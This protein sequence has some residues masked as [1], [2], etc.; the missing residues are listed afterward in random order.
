MILINVL[1]WYLVIALAG[2]LAFPLAFRL[3]PFLT[4]R[5]LSLSRPLGML[6]WGYV[7]W[8]LVS[9]GVLQN[10]AEGGLFALLCC[11]C[12]S[13]IMLRRG[14]WQQI[15][16]WL[17]NNSRLVAATEAVFLVSFLAWVVIRAAVPDA[18]GTE[19]PMELAFINSIL[20]SPSFPPADPWLSGYAISYY[21]FGYVLV[22]LL[23]RMVSVSGAVAFNLGIATWFALTALGAYGIL[24]NLIM[25][26]RDAGQKTGILASLLAPLFMLI[27]GNLEG[28][29]EMLHARGIFWRLDDSGAW[30]SGFWS[31]LNIQ[32]L[33]NPPATPLSWVPNRPF[34]IWWWRASRVLQD[35]ALDG[36]SREVIDEFPMFS[37]ILGD[38]HPHVLAMPF[39]LLAV[40]LALNIFLNRKASL[41]NRLGL[42]QWLKMPVF[43]LTSLVLGGLS[44]LNTWDFPIF[45]VLFTAAMVFPS[46]L[47]DG[48]RAELVRDFLGLAFS[49]GLAGFTLYLPFYLAFASQANG[50]LPSLVFFTRGIHLWVMFGLLLLPLIAWVAW[51]WG[52]RGSLVSLAQGGLFAI[53]LIAGLWLAS[54]LFGWFLINSDPSISGIWGSVDGKG[55]ILTSIVQRLVSPGAW[56]TLLALIAIAGGLIHTFRRPKGNLAESGNPIPQEN[57]TASPDLFVLLVILAGAGL[58]TLP[59]FFYLRDQFG[60]RMNTIFKFYFQ[61]WNL[62]AIAAGYAS[63]VLLRDLQG[64]RRTMFAVGWVILILLSLPYPVYGILS[65]TNNFQPAAWSLDGASYVERYS[66][67]EME[68]IRWMQGAP[69][70]VIAEAVGGSYTGYARISTH[71]GLPAVLGWPGHESQ[72]RGGALELGS[73][74]PDIIRLFR[75]KD[76]AQVDEVLQKY[77]IRYV[78]IGPL[79]KS[80]YHPD[81]TIFRQ[82]MPV[83]FQNTVVTI[84]ENSTL[85][86]Q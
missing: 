36:S 35:F 67:E 26:R 79:E 15:S 53:T 31:W 45:L 30:K 14:G 72:W 57:G 2:W 52:K 50:I 69:Y 32:E 5:G 60:F 11:A 27:S 9:F 28:F 39:A 86:S 25:L 13:F 4:D 64:P 33:T 21:Y 63:A 80:S 51:V 23:A 38:L 55:L 12:L 18:S 68:A 74:E 22:S 40:G 62:W 70:G 41:P 24:Y 83:V 3:L 56:L 19:K 82:H 49:L 61:G 65:R 16:C 48:W 78:Y 84:Y 1:L 37:Y 58:V 54:I 71:T 17:K 6:L 73:R 66:P 77:Q 7:F 20:R 8:L 46:Y 85:D 44:F 75:A 10:D 81:E 29:L 59:E 42:L 34:G 76:W 43:W 47:R